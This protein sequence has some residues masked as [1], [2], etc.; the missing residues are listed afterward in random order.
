MPK[1]CIALNI[2]WRWEVDSTSA[3]GGK[4]VQRKRPDGADI[5]PNFIGDAQAADSPDRECVP[6]VRSR[7][8]AYQ[9]CILDGA[10]AIT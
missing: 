7:D 6:K 5:C 8:P 4:A 10:A 2:V 9:G 1:K 3:F